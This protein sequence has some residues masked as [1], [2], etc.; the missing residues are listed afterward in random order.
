[1][2][3]FYTNVERRGQKIYLKYADKATGKRGK[4]ESSFKPNLFIQTRNAEKAVAKDFWDRDL[5]KIEFENMKEMSEFIERYKG[6][7]GYRI[8]GQRDPSFQ[9]I[10]RY[11]PGK[12]DFDPNMIHGGIVDIEVFSGDIEV[13]EDGSYGVIRGPFPDATNADYPISMLTIRHQHTGLYHVWGLETFKGHKI[14]TYVHNP[15]HDRVGKLSVI[16]KGFD[17]EKDMLADMVMW[18]QEQ[19]FDY[20]SGW[21]YEEFDVPYLVNRTKKMLGATMSTKFSPWGVIKERTINSPRGEVPTYEFMG[22]S[23]LDMLNLFKKHAFM[24][25]PNWKLNTV[26]MLVLGE[27]KISYDD[28][29]SL[30]NLYVLNYQKSVEYNIIDVD[31]VYRLDKKMQFFLLTY[32]LAYLTK[33]NYAD[34][35][36]TVKPWSA[37]ATSKLNERGIQPE[38]RG[39]SQAAKDIVGGFVKE[40]VPGFYR[41]VVSG[42]LNSLYP[43]LMQQYNLGVD[44]ILEPHEVPQEVQDSIPNNFTIDDLVEK[45][46]DL[47]VLKKYNITMTANRQFF[48]KDRMAIFNE[49]TREIY[50]GRAT[51]KKDM[52]KDEQELVNLL[53]YLKKN[54]A[55][56]KDHPD[57][58]A[59]ETAIAT[60]NNTQQ[61]YKILMNGLYGAMANKYFTEYFD[62][63]IAEGITTSGQLSI[64]WISRKANEYFNKVLGTTNV[65]YVVANDTDS[66]YLTLAPLIDKLFPGEKQQGNENWHKVANFIDKLFKEKIEPYIDECYAELAEYMNAHDQRMFMKRETIAVSAI[67]AAKKRY[68]MYAID[69]EGVRYPTPKVKYTGVDAKRSTFPEKCRE[70]MVECYEIALS[71]TEKELQARVKEIKAE[72]MK[73]TIMDIAGVTGVNNLEQFADANTVFVKGSPRHVKASLFHNKLIKDLGITRLKEIQS[74]DK[75]LLVNLKKGAPQ[76]IEAIAFQGDLP[77]EFGLHKYVDYQST[78]EK[79]FLEPV[80]NLMHAINWSAEPRANV[81]DFFS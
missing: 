75:I 70:W 50:T 76:G 73:Q 37:L 17:D 54:D 81:M 41:W 49:L 59:L 24:Q 40:V 19:D 80:M 63:R 42:D 7:G 16:Y 9:F 45:R 46:I 3:R 33:S 43:H 55:D 66:M 58:L 27:E 1:M 57:V 15:D 31:L 8:Y 69:V 26:A 64:K 77:V 44:T 14:G 5:E 34:T 10:D 65:D 67:W 68:V 36:G 74:G 35:L 71:G 39:V 13:K 38:L 52:K 78:Y 47:S 62:T 6:I 4:T 11:F 32:I 51:V 72:Y 61:A 23:I 22:S 56:A 12:I 60:K 2:T 30:N 53:D 79:T 18:W 20:T 21:Y 48:R 25:P 28:E 29:G